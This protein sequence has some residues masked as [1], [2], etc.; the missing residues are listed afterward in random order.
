[1]VA[2]GYK[3]TVVG[4]LP[5]DWDVLP[6]TKITREIFLGLTSKVDYV[7]SSGIPLIR[8]TDI[9]GGKLSFQKVRTISNKQ[10]KALTKYRKVKRDDI[11]V[12]K[13]GSLGVCAIVDVDDEFSIYESIIVLQ[14]KASVLSS[15]LLWL[16]RDERTQMRMI[17]EKVGSSVAHLNIEMFRQLV[18]QLP[19][20][21]EQQA[22]AE[23]LSDVDGLIDG[24]GK[25]IAKKRDIKT[26]TMQQLLT[27]KTRLPG[28]A[29]GKGY[30]QTELGEVPEDW[31]VIAIGDHI[32]LLTGYPFP[33]SQYS[34]SGIRLLRGSN[35]KRGVTDWN[36]GIVQYWSEVTTDILKYEL[37]EG[38][39]V[40]AMDGSLV[41]SSFAQLRDIDI[42]ALLLQRV[43]R[44]RTTHFDVGY[45]KEWVCGEIFTTH[46]DKV[47]TVTAI[48]H[49]SPED[50]RMFK[51]ASPPTKDEQ[52]A[53]AAVLIDMDKELKTLTIRLDKTKS[54]KKGMMQ[55]LL[56]GK[57][58]LL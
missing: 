16:M 20:L 29:E 53:I 50:I 46:C 49:I 45:L 17:G 30:K 14:P 37:A 35:I 1:M 21:P 22:I 36:E 9:A 2:A 13:S 43:A 39:I 11:L 26:A 42:P 12:S 44:I 5:E 58:R 3:Q 15:F 10:H 54:I 32:D 47:K 27:G 34:D 8:A 31:S 23:A 48:P 52:Q 57:T 6:V 38:D 24:L 7:E 4:V 56:M 40:I 25:L 55:E 51:I 19:P 28:F 41:G 33:S 18:V